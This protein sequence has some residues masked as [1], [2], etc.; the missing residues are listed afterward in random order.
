M[1][2]INSIVS[3]LEID[4]NAKNSINFETSDLYDMLE[5]LKFTFKSVNN[6]KIDEKSTWVKMKEIFQSIYESNR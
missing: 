1:I 5:I 4:E 2:A 6:M 3:Q